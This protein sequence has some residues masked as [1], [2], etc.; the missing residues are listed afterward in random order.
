MSRN[1]PVNGIARWKAIDSRPDADGDR[2]PQRERQEQSDEQPAG[3]AHRRRA[4]SRTSP[5]RAP[6]G[7]PASTAARVRA[8]TAFAR[9]APDRRRARTSTTSV[10]SGTDR[11][12]PA[13]PFHRLERHRI[14]GRRFRAG[15]RR[16]TTAS[17]A[18]TVTMSS[19]RSRITVANAAGRAHAFVAR[20]KVRA[21][22]LAGARRQNGARGEPDGRRAKRVAEAGRAERLEQVLPAPGPNREIR[23][24]SSTAKASATRG[25]RE[26]SRA[27]RRADRR[28]A[29]TSAS[30]AAASA[31]TIKSARNAIA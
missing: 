23:R 7:R 24:T 11:S 18:S 28:C 14:G 26:Q 1:D 25:A 31:S 6:A 27:R 2:Q 17:S 4:P 22:D 13:G 3:P 12:R 16:R 20:E 21:N 9:V 29:R 10:A 15:R 8:A 30:N 5:R 19:T